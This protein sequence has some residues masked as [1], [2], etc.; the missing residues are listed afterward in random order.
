MTILRQYRRLAEWSALAIIAA[1]LALAV[2]GNAAAQD[3]PEMATELIKVTNVSLD[4]AHQ[5]A[6]GV[7]RSAE[8]EC[9]DIRYLEDERMLAVSATPEVIA[10]IR[11]LLAEFDRLPVT[12]SFQIV[13]LAANRSG[14]PSADVP[15]NV[16]RALADVR[17]FLP[18]TGYSVV[19][20]GWL[21]TSAYGTTTLP[22]GEEFI[23]E[24]R[25]RPNT[26]PTAPLLIEDFSVF[27]RVAVN[28][29][30]E[31]GTTTQFA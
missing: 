5:L 6:L 4:S 8:R 29:A 28:V 31:S 11:A 26:D 2:P 16:E 9:G 30:T 17:D 3:Q 13:V 25:F 12:R 1:V 10:R 21:R 22:G 23:A 20:S 24:L 15:S 27:R 19:G 14:S 7:C 18:Y